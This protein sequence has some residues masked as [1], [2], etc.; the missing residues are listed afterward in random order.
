MFSD[1]LTFDFLRQRAALDLSPKQQAEFQRLVKVL[2]FGSKFQMIF[3]E[4]GNAALRDRLITRLGDILE[5]AHVQCTRL[6]LDNAGLED[7]SALERRLRDHHEAK[8][9]VIHIVNIEG[10]LD[11][12]RLRGLNLRRE[13]L[14]RELK[15]KLV[16]WAS[17]AML[18]KIALHAADL[19]SWRSGVYAFIEQ[20][21]NWLPGLVPAAFAPSPLAG[22]AS[23]S[24]CAKRIATLRLA[25]STVTDD[26][27]RAPLLDE[28]ASLLTHMGATSESLQL[29]LDE[30]IPIYRK[31]GMQRNEAIS[32]CRIAVNLTN[33]GAYEAALDYL[34]NHALPIFRSLGD[35]RLLS[36]AQLDIAFILLVRGKVSQAYS[37]CNDVVLPA[38]RR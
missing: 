24:D 29:R 3:A 27:T 8:F 4:I 2:R 5:P 37:L 19:W 33:Q 12:A 36:Q 16:F 10:W 35:E 28:L 20:Q 31:L 11:D 30:E 13:T 21:E 38:A 23:L 26:E 6:D 9:E 7:L 17:P 15:C 1:D 34:E 25:L 18:D 32:Y 14:A 22:H